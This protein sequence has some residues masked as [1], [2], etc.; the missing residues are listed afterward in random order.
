M[1]D[2]EITL[3]NNL[4][5]PVVDG[6]IAKAVYDCVRTDE[7]EVDVFNGIL[8]AI[9]TYLDE[10]GVEYGDKALPWAEEVAIAN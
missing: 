9:V 1:N 10:H 6:E 2:I 7:F 4:L 8:L 5:P 3:H